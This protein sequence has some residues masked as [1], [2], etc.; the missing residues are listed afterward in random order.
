[1][2]LLIEKIYDFFEVIWEKHSIPLSIAASIL[3]GFFYYKGL[4]VNIRVVTS[5]IVTFASIVIGVNGVFLTLII[6]LQES[7]A[8]VR[9]REFFPSFQTKLYLSLRNQI[10]YGL[11]VVIISI[12]INL[13]PASPSIYFSVFGVTIWFIFFFLMSIGSFISVKLVTDIIVKNFNIPTRRTRQ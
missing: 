1:V 5:T 9:L 7:P 8:F 3:I 2:I 11:I 4:I 12:A 10:V 13:L 6:T